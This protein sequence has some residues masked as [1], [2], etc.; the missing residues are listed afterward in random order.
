M[1]SSQRSAAQRSSSK[2]TDTAAAAT[3]AAETYA[4]TATATLAEG[5]AMCYIY[6]I[7]IRRRQQH[8]HHTLILQVTSQQQRLRQQQSKQAAAQTAALSRSAL[9]LTRALFT[10]SLCTAIGIYRIR[11]IKV[12]VQLSFVIFRSILLC[13]QHSVFLPFSPSPPH[14]DCL[15][16]SFSRFYCLSNFLA[17]L[18]IV[19]FHLLCVCVSV[20]ECGCAGVC[21]CSNCVGQFLSVAG[22]R[23]VHEN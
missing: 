9:S 20:C 23:N 3:A 7:S 11:V 16:A 13:C 6:S 5:R 14:R 4:A 17:Q 8:T 22:G 12:L 2:E 15:S 19:V 21:V 18:V 10:W 1:E